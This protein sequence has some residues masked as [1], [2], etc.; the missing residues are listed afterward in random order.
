MKTVKWNVAII[1]GLLLCTGCAV[2]ERPFSTDVDAIT[3]LQPGMDLEE[4]K[5]ALNTQVY[6]VTQGG[7]TL[8]AVFNY[9][10]KA[11]KSRD[12]YEGKGQL[13]YPGEIYYKGQKYVYVVFVNGKFSSLYTR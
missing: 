10:L 1:L 6:D 8:T 4:V 7:D 2:T 3:R 12:M 9:K 13:N 5:Q 11:Y